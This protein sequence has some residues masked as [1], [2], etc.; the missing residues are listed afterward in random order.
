[1]HEDFVRN[2]RLLCNYYRSVAEVCRRL[3]IN[4]SQFNRY[5][6]G[7]NLPFTHTLRKFCTFFGVEEHEI[8]MPSTQF[9]LLVQARPKATATN[10]SSL[11]ETQHLE[12]LKQA[13]TNTLDKYLDYYFETYLSMTYPDQILR[14]L[15]YL[16]KQADQVYY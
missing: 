2:L 15:V 1:M 10:Q 5:L 16:E 8:L 11:P 7:R 6:K 9:E 12:H 14:T 3:D 4:R 13:S